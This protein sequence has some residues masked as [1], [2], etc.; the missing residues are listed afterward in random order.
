MGSLINEDLT[1][2]MIQKLSLNEFIGF[3]SCFC[4]K[5]N[6][7]YKT[8]NIEN[9][10]HKSFGLQNLVKF[11]NE[12]QIKYQ[13]YETENRFVTGEFSEELVFDL[14]DYVI[15]WCNRLMKKCVQMY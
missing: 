2:K 14:V 15:E 4:I 11:I 3:L 13:S 5:V 9:C 7:N 1:S 12:L 10:K 8:Y 6:E